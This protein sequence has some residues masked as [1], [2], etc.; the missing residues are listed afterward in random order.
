[1]PFLS[2]NLERQNF[3][4]IFDNLI[5]VKTYMFV[6]MITMKIIVIDD[7]DDDD[8]KNN[9]ASHNNLYVTHQKM[10][11]K[12]FLTIRIIYCNPICSQVH[13]ANPSTNRSLF[14]YF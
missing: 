1:M 12:K 6:I 13:C 2:H 7:D 5:V 8:D 9:N 11:A 10:Q 3:E 14:L 4:V